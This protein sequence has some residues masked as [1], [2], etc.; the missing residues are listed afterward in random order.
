MSLYAQSVIGI[1]T[2]TGI[3]EDARRNGGR[4][5]LQDLVE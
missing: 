2:Y 1:F 3:E 5:I 4:N